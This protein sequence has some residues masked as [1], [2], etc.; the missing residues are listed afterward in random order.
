M[1]KK[2]ER[3]KIIEM[4]LKG[5]KQKD[6]AKRF[7]ISQSTVSIINKSYRTGKTYI[8]MPIPKENKL[9]VYIPKES[10]FEDYIH[11]EIDDKLDAILEANKMALLIGETGTGKTY[12]CRYYAYK[13][14]LPCL[15]IS[16]DDNSKFNH[17]L[18]F[19]EIKDNQTTFEPG[20]MVDFLQNP[21][22][23]LF[24]EINA[25]PAK[26]AFRFHEMAENR[27]LFIPELRKT[28]KI[29]PECRIAFACN[30]KNMRYI[31]TNNFNAAFLDRLIIIKFPHF[32]NKE[33]FAHFKVEDDVLRFYVE[34]VKMINRNEMRTMYSIRTIKQYQL[35][36]N[37]GFS[38]KEAFEIAFMNKA[39]LNEEDEAI[40]KLTILLL[41]EEE[42][43]KKTIDELKEYE[44]MKEK[45]KDEWW[46][47]ETPKEKK[48][49]EAK[50]KDEW[51]RSV[52]SDWDWEFTK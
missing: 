32:T 49:W 47:F 10:E 52:K 11:R 37:I 23:I 51:W 5:Y 33:L 7:G 15:I 22:L 26:A 40:K 19:R 43:T 41:R 36:R 20:L 25:L 18:G 38:K 42:K 39:M 21:S 27:S 30:Q 2:V 29:H 4:L 13:H 17:L 46:E 35:L 3:E 14:N 34:A 28:I 45:A 31:G 48:K 44:K 24:D 6:I 8:H 12:A 16:L 9:D 1:K 50:S